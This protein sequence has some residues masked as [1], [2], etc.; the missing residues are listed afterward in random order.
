M[1]YHIIPVTTFSQNCSLI[2]CEHTQQAVLFDPGG[3]AEKIKAEVARRGG[4]LSD[5]A[6]A[7][8]P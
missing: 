4:S 3:D 5:P 1:K 2:W 8:P 6:D 7:R